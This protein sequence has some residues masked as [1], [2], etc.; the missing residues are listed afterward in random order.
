VH[1][2][3][4]FSDLRALSLPLAISRTMYSHV[5]AVVVNGAAPR[6]DYQGFAPA[7]SPGQTQG[8]VVGPAHMNASP[9][10]MQPASVGVP[11][12]YYNPGFSMMAPGMRQD[13]YAIR[14]AG[15]FLPEQQNLNYVSDL[16]SSIGSTSSRYSNIDPNHSDNPYAIRWATPFEEVRFSSHA[17]FHPILYCP[18]YFAISTIGKIKL[19]YC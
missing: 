9:P 13:P 18:C 15:S 6:F 5:P 11:M 19:C 4:A 8:Y 12:S 14:R 3:E 2:E 1:L 7:V 10:M 16:Y 17:A